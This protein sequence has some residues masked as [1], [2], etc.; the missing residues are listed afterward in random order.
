MKKNILIVGGARSG[1]SSYAQQMA[2]RISGDRIYLATC[3][4][5]Q[6]TDLEM[7]AR[8]KRHRDERKNRGWKTLEEPVA[9]RQAILDNM[10][11]SVILVDCLTLWVSNLMLAHEGGVSLTEETIAQMGRDLMTGTSHF[12]GTLI[13]VTNEVGQGIVPENELARRYRDLMGRCN[14]IVAS[15]VDEIFV[16]HCG[17]PMKI[18]G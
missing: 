5:D 11:A 13:L 2:E 10:Q 16:V 12:Q 14:Q 1:K 18:K 6:R 4:A 8:I 7:Q 15:F 3:S 17:I 9:L